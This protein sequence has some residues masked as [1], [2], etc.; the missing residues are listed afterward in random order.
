M[1]LPELED[2]KPHG[3]PEPPLEKAADDWLFPVIDGVKY[4]RETNTMPQWAGSC[5]YFLRFIDPHNEERFCDPELEKTWMPVDLYIGGAEH[6]VLHLL[7][8]RFWHKVLFDR[9]HVHTNE[10]FQRLVN[11]GMILGENEFTGYRNDEEHWVSATDVTEDENHQPVLKSDP[12]VV[13]KAVSLEA[14][15]VEKK[16]EFFVIASEPEIRLNSRAFKMSKARGNVV[17]PEEVIADHGADALRLYEMFMGPLEQSKP[18]NMK[19]VS[20]VKGF[21]DRAWRMV[22]DE[23]AEEMQ[24][25]AAVGDHTPTEE[26]TRIL[27]K[28]IMAVSKDIEKL[29]FNT[30]ISRMMEFVNFFT[31]QET[32]PKSIME[33]FVLLLSPMAPHLCEELWSML[34]HDQ[35]LAY[36]PWPQ[37]DESLTVESTVE[38]P[39]QILGKLR[40]RITVE[41]GLS[42]DA[43]EAAALADSRIQN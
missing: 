35:T 29:S 24:L 37:Y 30:A 33:Q 7:Y 1:Q 13:L 36:E 17:N 23:R 2:F 43:L 28:T 38:I 41:R 8:S 40:S 27:H 3:R 25:H 16:G 42:K 22:I 4:R 32:R 21:L 15:K 10:P 26:Q 6:A 11:Q 39:V 31:G 20:G 34:G 12:T 18:W 14:D 19:G 5:W 9:G